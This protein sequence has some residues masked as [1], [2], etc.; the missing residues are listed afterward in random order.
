MGYSRLK[1]RLDVLSHSP[2]NPPL[3]QPLSLGEQAPDVG[4]V[5]VTH[6]P[7]LPSRKKRRATFRDTSSFRRRNRRF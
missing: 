2:F 3:Q 4:Y 1:L 5:V 7:A 6:C